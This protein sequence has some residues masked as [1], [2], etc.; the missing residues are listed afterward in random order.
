VV[1]KSSGRGS[2]HRVDF[3]GVV[4]FL[5]ERVNRVLHVRLLVVLLT[6]AESEDVREELGLPE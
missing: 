1:F 3:E 2:I 5:L 6:V 4:G